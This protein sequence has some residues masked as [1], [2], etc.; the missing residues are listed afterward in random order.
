MEHFHQD[1]IDYINMLTIIVKWLVYAGAI[2]LVGYLL[3]GIHVANF[4]TALIAAAVL[5]IINMTIRPV[6]RLL[7]FPV[8]L[9]TLG[10]FG[11]VLNTFLF[12][13]ATYFV[14]GFSIDGFWFAAIGAFV[15]SIVSTIGNYIFLGGDGKFG[16]QND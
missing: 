15:V 10:L 5:G 13:S 9:L 8:N 14:Q 7:T 6:L 1:V 3:P 4:V 11:F 12:W 2:M 16:R